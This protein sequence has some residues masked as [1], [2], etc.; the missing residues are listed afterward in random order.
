MHEERKAEGDAPRASAERS[1]YGE[2]RGPCL[3]APLRSF[4]SWQP[5]AASA[6]RRLSRAL[7]FCVSVALGRGCTRALRFHDTVTRPPG[8]AGAWFC[9]RAARPQ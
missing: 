7:C 3:F 5:V 1:A 9:G 4:C 8:P 6:P 2:K